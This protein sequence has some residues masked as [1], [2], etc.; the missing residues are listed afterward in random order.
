[1]RGKSAQDQAG[2][3]AL[4]GHLHIAGQVAHQTR[5]HLA[6]ILFGQ[7][8]GR[9]TIRRRRSSKDK[10]VQSRLN[11]GQ[12]WRR[13]IIDVRIIG[14]PLDDGHGIE[15]QI[16]VIHAVEP[17]YGGLYDHSFAAFIGLQGWICSFQPTRDVKQRPCQQG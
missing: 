11:R 17:G 5:E 6:R 8:G 7:R 13:V 12:R 10:T 15:A 16:R 4:A 9:A 14:H 2:P 3:V 1:V